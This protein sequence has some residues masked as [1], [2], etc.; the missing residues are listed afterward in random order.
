MEMICHDLRNALILHGHHA[1]AVLSALLFPC[2]LLFPLKPKL[3]ADAE[4]AAESEE[5]DEEA[6]CH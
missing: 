6:Q 5:E 3:P 4:A 1:D 2:F